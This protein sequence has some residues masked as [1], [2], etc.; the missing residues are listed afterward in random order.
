MNLSFIIALGLAG[1]LFI[2]LIY[3]FFTEWNAD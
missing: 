1:V 2:S 3:Y